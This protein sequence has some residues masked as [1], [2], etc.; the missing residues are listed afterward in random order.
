[1]NRLILGEDSQEFT[2]RSS[3]SWEC[4]IYFWVCLC[5]FMGSVS[6]PCISANLEA[7]QPYTWRDLWDGEPQWCHLPCWA[8][9]LQNEAIELLSVVLGLLKQWKASDS[10]LCFKWLLSYRAVYHYVFWRFPVI[11]LPC[12]HWCRW[13]IIHLWVQAMQRTLISPMMLHQSWRQSFWAIQW[14]SILLD[15]MYETFRLWESLGASPVT[16]LFTLVLTPP[17]P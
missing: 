9:Q 3:T 15:G 8:G 10:S 4:W 1:M 11:L 17:K 13:V 5:S 16:K 12:W 6:V 7:L 14:M 2:T